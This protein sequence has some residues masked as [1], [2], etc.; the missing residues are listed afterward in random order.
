MSDDAYKPVDHINWELTDKDHTFEWLVHLCEVFNRN[1]R[2]QFSIWPEDY[3]WRSHQI[4]IPEE[5]RMMWLNVIFLICNK[6]EITISGNNIS[7]IG[8]FGSE[9]KFEMMPDLSDWV[10]IEYPLLPNCVPEELGSDNDN[11]IPGNIE[12]CWDCPQGISTPVGLYSLIWALLDESKAWEYLLDWCFV[13]CWLC[14][15]SHPMHSQEF[16]RVGWMHSDENSSATPAYSRTRGSLDKRPRSPGS[17]YC[18]WGCGPNAPNHH[19]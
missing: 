2:Q 7:V 16:E 10:G 15:E 8:K 18:C 3:L 1:E 12:L 5:H 14:R 17:Y 4:S 6:H 19:P 11:Y 9:F 13:E